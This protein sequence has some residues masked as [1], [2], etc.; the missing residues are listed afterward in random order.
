MLIGVDWPVNP[1][2]MLLLLETIDGK[3]LMTVLS[4]KKLGENERE[5]E[6]L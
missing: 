6:G 1:T 3:S 5:K 2:E 4:G